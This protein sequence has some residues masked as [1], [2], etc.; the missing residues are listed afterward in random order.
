MSTLR[1]SK[2]RSLR[3]LSLLKYKQRAPIGIGKTRQQIHDAA[4]RHED[5]VKRRIRAKC[6]TRDGY[7]FFAGAFID[8]RPH[9]CRGP[10]EWAHLGDKKR[11]RTVNQPPEQR[12]TTAGSC[13]LCRTLHRAYDAGT[14]EIRALSDAGADGTLVAATSASVIVSKS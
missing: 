4:D 1:R 13:M 5:R 7:C 9:V 11:A 8:R 12:H 3:S 14:I 10:S 6:V 2:A